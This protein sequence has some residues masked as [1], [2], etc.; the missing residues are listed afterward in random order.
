MGLTS[1]NLDM[2]NMAKGKTGWHPYLFLKLINK[3]KYLLGLTSINLDMQGTDWYLYLQ[4][5]EFSYRSKRQTVHG[6]SYS[7]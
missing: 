7:V 6:Q 3:R 5:V 4:L 1:V 2:T